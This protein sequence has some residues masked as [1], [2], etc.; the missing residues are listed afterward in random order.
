MVRDAS[1]SLGECLGIAVL[2]AGLT[3][4]HP[5]T[6]FQVASV[7]S[8]L[9]CSLMAKPCGH[10]TLWLGNVP[11]AETPPLKPDDAIR[12]KLAIYAAVSDL[13]TEI[14]TR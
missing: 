4:W 9:E 13:T 12:A 2:A 10:I 3:F 14:C 5:R 11:A 8:I 1:E 6:G 7:H